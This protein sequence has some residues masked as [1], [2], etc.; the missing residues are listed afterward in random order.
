MTQVDRVKKG[1]VTPEI[2]EIA[3]KEQRSVEFI[4]EGV[5]AGKIV[6][7]KN[8]NRSFSAEAV[9]KGLKTKVNANI[10]TSPDCNNIENEMLK[11]QTAVKYG[12]HSVMDLSIGG[13]L[14]GMRNKVLQNSPV[15]VG[16]VPLYA[17]FAETV[18][19]GGS[20]K[21]IDGERLFAAIEQQ[22]KEGVDFMTVHCGVNRETFEFCNPDNRV[23]GIVSR[24]GSLTRRWMKETGRDNPLYE[25]FDRLL[26]IAMRYDVTISLGDGLR[27]GGMPDAT[28]DLQLKELSVL[29]RLVERCRERNVQVMVEGPGH[30]PIQDIPFN[31]EIQKKVCR[32]APFYVL[33]P[34]VIDCAPG[35]DHITAAIGGAVAAWHGADFLCY[36]TPAEHLTLPDVDDVREGVVASIIAAQAGDV[37]KNVPGAYSKN[38]QMTRFRKNLDWENMYACSVDPEL[39]KK[40]RDE[41][42]S[43][44]KDY[45]TM[46]GSLCAL[47]Q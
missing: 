45:C 46:C 4:C 35:Y 15:M 23:A 30:V 14:N 7:P 39:P 25:Q 37:A 21:D 42:E 5:S 29:G 38:L 36:V 13:D 9:G 22:A 33:G 47:K 44:E 16:T 43:R 3:L 24:G 10:G 28:D 34:L 2:K 18:R 6:I 8:I 31:M 17:V 32:E 27:P 26:E 12:A 20:I 19:D 1:E 40:R 11:L 41:S